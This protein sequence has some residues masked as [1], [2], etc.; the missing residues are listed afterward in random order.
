MVGTIKNRVYK[1]YEK[2][3]SK[4]KM[5]KGGAWT[6]NLMGVHLEEIDLIVYETKKFIYIIESKKAEEVG[7]KLVFGGEYKLVVA[8]EYWKKLKKE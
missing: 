2:E 8:L 4:L 1:K 5:V 6:I 3:S 7:S